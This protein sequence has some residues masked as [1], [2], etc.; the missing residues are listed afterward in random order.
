[1]SSSTAS[2][3]RSFAASRRTAG[4][5]AG[6][7][8][9]AAGNRAAALRP[10]AATFLQRSLQQRSLQ[11][12]S[13]QQTGVICSKPRSTSVQQ[14]ALCSNA[15]QR[16][17]GAGRRPSLPRKPSAHSKPWELRSSSKPLRSTSDGSNEPSW[18]HLLRQHSSRQHCSLQQLLSSSTPGAGFTSSQAF[19]RTA[20][21]GLR[22]KQG[23]PASQQ[24]FGRQSTSL[25]AAL[26]AATLL[27]APSSHSSGRLACLR[28]AC[29]GR[30]RLGSGTS[31]R[32]HNSRCRAGSPERWRR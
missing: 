4:G 3:G 12:R 19:G 31:G 1:M 22:S 14:H 32:L 29:G 5:R 24:H 9:F 23:Q 21:R 13:L 20:S 7:H 18:Q 6:L 2:Y 27:A 26:L 8:F 30:T 15:L 16:A 28:A 11:Q 10:A 17:A 25:A